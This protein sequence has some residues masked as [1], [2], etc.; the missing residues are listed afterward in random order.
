[1]STFTIVSAAGRNQV[2]FLEELLN[3]GADVN[4]VE[5]GQSALHAACANGAREAVEILIGHKADFNLKDESKGQTALHYCAAHN[6]YDI[7]KMILENGGKP[8]VADNFGNQALW[9]V[10]FNVKGKPERFPMVELFLKH[11]ADKNHKNNSGR[12]PLDF[13][14][15]LKYEP[16]IELL[17]KT[18]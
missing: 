11:G 14:D 13:A 8:D 7:A 1:M 3:E 4:Q 15:I 6:Y 16:L 17:N 18:V 12:S 9:T 5:E 2:K 10:V